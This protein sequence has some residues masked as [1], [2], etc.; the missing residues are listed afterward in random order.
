M[1]IVFDLICVTIIYYELSYAHNRCYRL[2]QQLPSQ[3]THV[4][5]DWPNH[6]IPTAMKINGAYLPTG[7]AKPSRP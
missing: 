7:T 5:N 3:A 4:N 6:T 1:H 2:E